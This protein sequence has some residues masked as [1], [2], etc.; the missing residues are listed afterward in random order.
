MGR[1]TALFERLSS[2]VSL[3][4]NP[5]L[6]RQSCHQFIT[7]HCLNCG[8][9]WVSN[10]PCSD[11]LCLECSMKRSYKHGY[12][13]FAILS[14]LGLLN[15]AHRLKFVTLTIKNV[16]SVS[17][18]YIKLRRCFGVLQH[19]AIWKNAFY[20][21]KNRFGKRSK[22]WNVRGG[23]G[24]FEV[25]NTGNG[26]HV[27]LHLLLDSDF[28]PQ[29]QLSKLW[30]NITGD[31]KVVDVR[32]CSGTKE[33]I[34]EISK[35]SFKPADAVLWSDDMRLDF[36]VALKNKVLFFRFGSW[37]DVEFKPLAAKCGFCGSTLIMT[38]TFEC[39]DVVDMVC[40]PIR[41]YGGEYG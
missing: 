19:R 9:E 26:Y 37:R 6:N 11:K 27:H 40:N 5:I 14:A 23:M 8:K 3:L 35:Y 22:G 12:V 7:Q 29:K 21:R 1:Y 18:G 20:G 15:R 34:M 33:A 28:I 13:V 38:L 31:S 39:A 41:V 10:L 30:L 24:N 16:S 2:D 17:E 4:D 36:N 25:T 32:V